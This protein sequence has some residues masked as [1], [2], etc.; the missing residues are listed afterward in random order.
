MSDAKYKESATNS[1]PESENPAETTSTAH[2]SKD[3]NA[4]AVSTKMKK[5]LSFMNIQDASNDPA[6]QKKRIGIIHSLIMGFCLFCLLMTILVTQEPY[7]YIRSNL[8]IQKG[9]HISTLQNDEDLNTDD[10]WNWFEAISN[11]IGGNTYKEVV[12]NC[13]YNPYASQTINVDG[14]NYTVVNP[15]KQDSACAESNIGFISGRDDPLYLIGSHQLLAAGFFTRRANTN[16]PIKG[17]VADVESTLEINSDKSEPLNP[18]KDNKVV[19]VCSVLVEITNDDD[20]P[21]P[22]PPPIRRRFLQG[23]DED[24]A[25]VEITCIHKDGIAVEDVPYTPGSTMNWAGQVV[26]QDF[27]TYYAFDADRKASFFEESSK[28]FT[29]YP[30]CFILGTF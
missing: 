11:E 30:P 5:A 24:D 16:F 22:P 19:E 21:P 15:V 9:A 17:S 2:K 29:S 6:L 23:D 13:G 7:R 1:P 26:H 4:S 12:A 28:S 3:V 25:Y 8:A 20:I 14:T 27:N 18:I 10:V